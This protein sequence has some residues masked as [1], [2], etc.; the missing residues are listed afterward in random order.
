[1]QQAD[2]NRAQAARDLQV[3]RARMALLPDLP[4]G[5][6]T[7]QRLQPFQVPQSPQVPPA[8][9]PQTPGVLTN[10]S[11]QGGGFQAGSR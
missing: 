2:A 7:P 3:A 8:T 5:A 6:S 11:T 1:L 9:R 4:L 10:V